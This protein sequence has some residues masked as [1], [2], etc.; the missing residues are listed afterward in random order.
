MLFQDVDSN[1][2]H[3]LCLLASQQNRGEVRE[4]GGLTIASAGVQFAMF[5][6]ALISA[7]VLANDGGLGRRIQ[8]AAIHFQERGLDWSCWICDHWLEEPLRF[9][10]GRIFARHGLRRA[11]VYPGMVAERVLPASRPLPRLEIRQVRGDSTQAAFSE[12]GCTC[13]HMPVEWFREIFERDT[14]WESGFT[15]FVGYVDGEA[16]TT[17]AVV[18]AAGSIGVYNVATLPGFERRGYGE[19]IVRHALRRAQQETGIGRA[20]L[21]AT[22]QGFPLYARMGFRTVTRFAIYVSR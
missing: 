18:A 2:R 11:T 19:S 21:Q 16:V 3:T 5:N 17:A 15:G 8:D 7:P 13:F 1:L 10:S 14:L 20:V 9:E 4:A 12:V 6:A 22:A